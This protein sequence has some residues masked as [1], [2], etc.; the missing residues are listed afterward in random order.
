MKA[1]FV[2]ILLCLVLAMP[3]RAQ[4]FLD[5]VTVGVGA[6]FSFPLATTADHMKPGFNF[7]ATGGPRFNRR[8]SVALDFSLHYMDVD[9]DFL[10]NSEGNV[11]ISFGSLVRVWSL[12]VNPV[13][14]FIK[15][16]RFSSYATG[17]YGLYNRRLLLAAPG[18]IP[19]VAC[20]SF[21]EIC[22]NSGV[23]GG[24]VTGELGA[25]KGGYNAGMG[26]TF[27]AQSKFFTEVR[28][29]RMFT[30]KAATQIIPLTFGVRW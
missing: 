7:T 11:N 10:Q 26:I 23:P 2:S 20:D 9:D 22:V 30:P 1:L 4:E 27:G 17:G 25:Y 5:H 21:W 24:A 6:G 16:D 28:Y 3:M 15:Q 8:L 14:E 18:V 13:Y 19:A 29:H 12:T